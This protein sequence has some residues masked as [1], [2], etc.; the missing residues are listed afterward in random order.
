MWIPFILTGDHKNKCI[1]AVL[2]FLELYTD[3]GDCILTCIV[4]GDKT[5]VLYATH[6]TKRQSKKWHHADT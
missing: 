5:W 1:S 4:T 6:K 3:E 2:K